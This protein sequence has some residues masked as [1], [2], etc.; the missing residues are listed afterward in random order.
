MAV[1]TPLTIDQGATFSKAIELLD[2]NQEPLD[3]TGYSVIAQI[4]KNYTSTNYVSFTTALENGSVTISLSANTS[5]VMKPDRYVYDV[6]LITPSNT[7]LRISEGTL[8][9]KPQVSR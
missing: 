6:K 7:S 4:R 3:V 2:T 9:L 8:T 5:T 1:N